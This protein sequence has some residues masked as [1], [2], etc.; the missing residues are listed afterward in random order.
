MFMRVMAF[1]IKLRK[2]FTDYS[3]FA[4]KT[5]EEILG[6]DA[7]DNAEKLEVHTLASG[8]L[9]NDGGRFDFVGFD[10][11]LQVAPV[12]AM[13]NFDF[14]G[15]GKEEV[16]FAGNYFGITPYHGKFDALNGILLKPNEDLQD[17]HEL[18][19]D[20]FNKMVKDLSIIHVKNVPYLLVTINN[21]NVELYKLGK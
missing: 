18:G 7:L 6:V 2:K 5:A 10:Y 15:D 16:I 17:T 12:R 20:L 11:P 3:E 8:Y 9:R 21:H 13:L 19:L 1:H 4:G 14:D